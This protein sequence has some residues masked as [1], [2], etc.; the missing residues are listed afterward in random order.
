[1]FCTVFRAQDINEYHEILLYPVC[2][3]KGLDVNVPGV[4]GWL[5]G[6]GHEECAPVVFKHYGGFM[7]GYA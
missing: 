4:I 5:L 6:I 7:L 2:Q 3:S 1:V